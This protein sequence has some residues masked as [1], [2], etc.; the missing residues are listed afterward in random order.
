MPDRIILNDTMIGRMLA[1]QARCEYGDLSTNIARVKDGKV[2]GGAVYQA[3]T[4]ESCV[5]HLASFD[6]RWLTRDLCWIGHHYP[7]MQLGVKRIFGQ[8]PED[9]L[10]ARRLN[11]HGGFRTI[12]RIEGVYR[13][14]VAC[15][16]MVLE[17]E[18]SRFL[19][20]P[21]PDLVRVKKLEDA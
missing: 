19:K 11:E 20:W 6:P 5:M 8:V 9:N 10:K 1:R 3:Y 15:L 4:G 16:V 17:K 21:V 12:A 18:D 7:F 2:M 13:D 14:G